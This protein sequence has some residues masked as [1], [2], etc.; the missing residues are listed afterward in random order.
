MFEELLLSNSLPE[1]FSIK[2]ILKKIC[3]IN[4]KAPMLESLFKKIADPQAC[5]S[6]KS[7]SST[8][9]CFPVNLS[10]FLRIPIL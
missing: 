1:V 7:N 5:S 9:I 2:D 6:I 8:G 4:R 10:K 3:K